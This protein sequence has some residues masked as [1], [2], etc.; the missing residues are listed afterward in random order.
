MV[1]RFEAT[2]KVSFF[3]VFYSRC[4]LLY[5]SVIVYIFAP[6]I[7]IFL[8][9][10]VVKHEISRFYW[11]TLITSLKGKLVSLRYHVLL[12]LVIWLYVW[13]WLFA[14]SRVQPKDMVL[15]II[16]S[17]QREMFSRR[18]YFL[19]N[20]SSLTIKFVLNTWI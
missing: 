7:I 14:K 3:I 8:R 13:G 18:K 11:E 17:M 16:S 12:L 5:R 2:L 6:G 15:F 1:F 20:Y 19:E 9:L 4:I 10:K